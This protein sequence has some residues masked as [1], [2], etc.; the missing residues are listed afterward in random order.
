MQRQAVPV[1]CSEKCIIRTGLERQVASNMQRQAVPVSRS[2]KCIIRT[3]LERQVAL[4]SKVPA[5][6][7]HEEKIIST[8][9]DKIILS[10]HGDC[11]SIPLIM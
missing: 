2:E 5:I 10:G 9:T 7:D 6:A 11:Q 8:D 4:D 3:G 1:S